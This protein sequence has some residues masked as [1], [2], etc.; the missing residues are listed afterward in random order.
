MHSIYIYVFFSLHAI[1]IVRI[2]TADRKTKLRTLKQQVIFKL[3]DK[4]NIFAFC[5][6]LLITLC[7]CML[8]P[9]LCVA[10]R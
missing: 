9:M 6:T 1:S 7:L 4:C 8:M 2:V 10:N 3:T 5:A